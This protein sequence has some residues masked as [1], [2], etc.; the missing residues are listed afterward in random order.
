MD[1]VCVIVYFQETRNNSYCVIVVGMDSSVGMATY[2][3]MV[4][5]GIESRWEG[6]GRNFQHSSQTDPGARRT[7]LVPYLFRCGNHPPP[8]SVGVK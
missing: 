8:P 5:P 6:G 4:G 3:R 7:T 2:Y 1:C